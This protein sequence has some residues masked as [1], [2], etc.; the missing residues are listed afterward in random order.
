MYPFIAL[1]TGL[2]LAASTSETAYAN[3]QKSPMN[4]GFIGLNT[5]P[6]ARMNPAGKITA[7]LSNLDPFIH[8][9]IGL[10]IA[11][12]LFVNIR[13]TAEISNINKDAKHLYPGLDL[14]LRLL[15]ETRS[16]PEV[17][18]G[19]QSAF[20][21]KR[22]AGEFIALSKRHNN[23]DLTMGIGWGRYGT[24]A[25]F[26]NPL[27]SISSHFENARDY[28][29]QLPNEPQHWFTGENVGI[30][31]GIEYFLP[32]KGLSVKIDYGADRYTAEKAAF[33]FN[34]PSPWSA[35][36]SYSPF[37]WL[38]AGIAIQ[39]TDK[40]MS[41][42]SLQSAP[43]KWPLKGHKYASPKPFYKH[44]SGNQP[45]ITTII[46]TAAKDDIHLSNTHF[47]G[48]S[49]FAELEIPQGANTPKHIGR[50]IRIIAD[51]SGTEI[52]EII[53]T[54]T[55]NNL[56]GATIKT[57]RSDVEKALDNSQGSPQEI[58]KNTEF[59][60]TEEE[61]YIHTP[62]MHK[63]GGNNTISYNLTLENQISLSE[64]DS[65]TLYRAS[66]IGET[67]TSPFLGFFTGSALRLNIRD[68]LDNLDKLRPASL[69]PIKDDVNAFTNERLSLEN[70][71][72]TY[73]HSLN[74][75]LHTSISAGYL[76]EFYAGIGGQILYRPFKSR[77]SL[78][79]EIWQVIR[80]EP[81]TLLNIG[82]SPDGITTG[83]INA[84][85]DL[86]HHDITLKAHAGRFLATDIGFGL[87]LEKK[88]NN[89]ASLETD[90]A[91]SNAA[92][93]DI[94]G[95]T[96]HAYHS[97]SLKLPLGSLPYITS[98]STANTIIAPFGRNTAQSLNKP[99]DL[100]KKTEGFTLN[101]I[102]NHWKEILD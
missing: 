92:D 34:T 64:E 51:H 79:G 13:Q 90:F 71:H 5:V 29:S 21:H 67:K 87:G 84:W 60:V 4:T 1:V 76:E 28:N 95:G 53:I 100:Y 11:D 20:G 9:Y 94:F 77:L 63:K 99:F 68:N 15:K 74:P 66:I 19:L 31:G 48:Q 58:W 47:S 81:D 45:N 43:E 56:R 26:K 42:I 70:A 85:Y 2:I 59:L 78:G 98:G 102:A 62:F 57:M 55:R 41:R 82:L 86:P 25:H 12:P 23:L 16:Q 3:Q 17:S 50:A 7:G 49:I 69:S 37:D 54:P 52:E 93:H 24:A 40:I 35:G 89:G 39:G 44:R 36:L 83:H 91:I 27:K 96:T 88:F 18:L 14:K 22:M 72:I 32:V 6:T 101:H 80:R 30:F 33:A 8:A 65:G 61:N 75:A 73:A 97:I 38:N 46:Q 10:Q